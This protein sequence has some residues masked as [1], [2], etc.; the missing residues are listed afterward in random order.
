MSPVLLVRRALTYDWPVACSG[1]YNGGTGYQYQYKVRGWARG[2][3]HQLWL[4]G[5]VIQHH[6]CMAHM[7]F[8]PLTA[9]PHVQ[10]QSDLC[11]IRPVVEIAGTEHTYCAGW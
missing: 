7:Y 4:S 11:T 3:P 2:A 5:I 6:A 8:T 1:A 10:S 9:P